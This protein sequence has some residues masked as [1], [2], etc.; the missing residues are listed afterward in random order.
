MEEKNLPKFDP[1]KWRNRE[2]T[3]LNLELASLFLAAYEIMKFNIIDSVAFSFV[4]RKPV[5]EL[6]AQQWIALWGDEGR[7]ML[8]EW[9][10]TNIRQLEE[11]KQMVGIDYKVRAKK[12]LIPSCEYLLKCNALS[13]SDVENVKSIRKHRNA[14]AHELPNFMFIENYNVRIEFLKPIREILQ[15]VSIYW[16]R[17]YGDIPDHIPDDDV[18]PGSVMAIDVLIAAVQEHLDQKS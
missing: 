7:R 11:Y 13:E 12:G 2:L 3:R 18:F 10:Q 9:R 1:E 14:V 4:D 15:K 8:E 16:A 17:I 5:S 6:D